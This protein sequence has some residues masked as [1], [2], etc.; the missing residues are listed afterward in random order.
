MLIKLIKFLL[1]IFLKQRNSKY[2]KYA[3]GLSISD[4]SII[5]KGR[6]KLLYKLIHNFYKFNAKVNFTNFISIF[7]ICLGFL[8]ILHILIDRNT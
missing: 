4:F 7:K 2:L 3:L 5:V 8:I 1:F 6:L